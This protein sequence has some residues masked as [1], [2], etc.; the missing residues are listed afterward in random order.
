MYNV[1]TQIHD[2]NVDFALKLSNYRSL[3]HFKCLKRI[4]KNFFTILQYRFNH[5]KLPVTPFNKLQNPGLYLPFNGLFPSFKIHKISILW[6]KDH[7]KGFKNI[8][9]NLALWNLILKSHYHK[10]YV[11]KIKLKFFHLNSHFKISLLLIS[12]PPNLCFN[13]KSPKSFRIYTILLQMLLSQ[14][15]VYNLGQNICNVISDRI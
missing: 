9:L 14:H 1:P 12:L 6:F 2:F 3:K 4:L 15:F 7:N 11:S 13:F 8:S 5:H 10:Y